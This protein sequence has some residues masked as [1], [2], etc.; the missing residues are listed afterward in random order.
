MSAFNQ[1]LYFNKINKNKRIFINIYRSFSTT[2]DKTT[3]PPSSW[4]Q[5]QQPQQQQPSTQNTINNIYK[6][7][8]TITKDTNKIHLE[9]EDEE[10][11]QL[12]ISKFNRD[13][14][15]KPELIER[16]KSL[17]HTSSPLSDQSKRVQYKMITEPQIYPISGKGKQHLYNFS[18]ESIDPAIFFKQNGISLPLAMKFIHRMGLSNHPKRILETIELLDKNLIILDMKSYGKVLSGLA[19]CKDI[20]NCLKIF[21]RMLE[22]G[23][24]PSNHHF[25]SLIVAHMNA[26][27][28][29]EAFQ[30]LNSME[31]TYKLLPDHVNFTSMINGLV[32]NRKT[33]LAIQLFSEARI[34]GMQPDSVTLSVMVDACAKEDR[35][36]KAFQY[37]EEFKYLNL[38]PT[39]ITFN[40][41]INACAK[42]SDDYYYLKSFELLQDMAVHN[43]KPDIITYTS[44]MNGAAKRGE[45]Q[46]FEKIYRELLYNRDDFKQQPDSRVF[47]IALYGYAVNQIAVKRNFT[48]KSDLS[49][50]IEKAEAVLQEM[51][52]RGISITKYPLDEYLK[53]L[54]HSGRFNRTKETFEQLYQKNNIQPDKISYGIMIK[55]Y[56]DH[57]RFEK[58]LELLHQMKNN[59]VEADYYIYLTLLHGSAKVGYAKTC[60]KIAN[61]M[62]RLGFPP[63]IEDMKGI[64][65]RF[66]EY[67]EIVHGIKRICVFGEDDDYLQNHY[68]SKD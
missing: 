66:K 11:K 13:D 53:V 18:T 24:K 38:P 35:V 50:N 42:R 36:E 62:N 48:N 12:N 63:K 41:L 6:N 9:K 20:D 56:V 21:E 68:V 27:K 8:I 37:F 33:K 59:G 65:L 46:V 4:E 30:I 3:Q 52:S 49:V 61:E 29:D 67:P 22:E 58:A 31:T 17:P 7:D 34:K 39:E 32:R 10:K 40:S 43:F 57:K 51:Q 14:Y 5:S 25:N 1:L 28:I 44:L 23:I 19:N 16:A 2:V 15:I 60:L 55:M 64:L 26:G 54:A 47:T 45:V